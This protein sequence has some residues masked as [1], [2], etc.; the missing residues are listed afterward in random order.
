MPQRK[1][2][3]G[4]QSGSQL[5]RHAIPDQRQVVRKNGP[6]LVVTIHGQ[7]FGLP[8]LSSLCTPKHMR[9][10]RKRFIFIVSIGTDNIRAK[11]GGCRSERCRIQCNDLSKL[12]E[13]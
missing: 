6:K 2:R 10:A 11:S 13:N 5:I 8:F 4:K 3:Q 9:D 1:N 12:F 7:D